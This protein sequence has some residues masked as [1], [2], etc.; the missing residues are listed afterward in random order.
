[1]AYSVFERQAYRTESPTLVLDPTGRIVI[2]AAGCRLLNEADVKWVALL[3]DQKANRI[4]IKAVPKSDKNA[5]AVS[6]RKT[7]IWASVSATSFLR[8]I[9]WQGKGREH[10][11]A[12][13]TQ[14]TR[15]L[16]A[17]L[18]KGS[19][20]PEEGIENPQEKVRRSR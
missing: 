16:E 6:Y 18:S 17:T 13:W 4:A 9:G 20:S 1:M 8:H 19:R 12:T 3:W 5:F 11:A 2:N 14:A 10:Y 7:M 15:M